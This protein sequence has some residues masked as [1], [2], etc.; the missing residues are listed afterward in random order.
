M[1]LTS[2]VPLTLLCCILGFL[3]HAYQKEWIILLLPHQT[4]DIQTHN[5]AADA[6]FTQKKIVLFF[7]K[8]EQWHKEHNSV[9]W[10]SNITHNVKTITNNW[11]TLL[12]DE[13]IIDNDIQLISAVIGSNKELF[14]SF[15]KDLHNT[16]SSTYAKLM[17]IHGLL[18]TMHENKI[19]VQ[20]VRFL[21]HH[22]TLSDDHLNF[23]VSWPITGYIS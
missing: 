13:K 22:Q 19:P 12:E 20:S 14:L 5:Q 11:L 1:K 15:N 2:L 6:T 8:H 21:I 16:Q 18:K 17:M 4:A 3:F 7:W 10:S 9:I 23:S